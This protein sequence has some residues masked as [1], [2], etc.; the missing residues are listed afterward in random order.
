MKHVSDKIIE[1]VIATTETNRTCHPGGHFWDF[2]PGN[3]SF[4][5]THWNLF[6]DEAPVDFIYRY[7]NFNGVAETWLHTW[8][9]IRIVVLA[10][11]A[12]LNASLFQTWVFRNIM[13]NMDSP[14]LRSCF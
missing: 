2:Y 6:E 14:T 11:A 5:S 9:G 12:R 10:I 13:Q 1:L 8:Q 4:K 7:L 3:I